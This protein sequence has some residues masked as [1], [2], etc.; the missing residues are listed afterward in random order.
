MSP[1]K[2]HRLKWSRTHLGLSIGALATFCLAHLH[3]QASYLL[4]SATLPI[5]IEASVGENQQPQVVSIDG[6]PTTLHPAM[7]EHLTQFIRSKG[8]P[9]A[10]VVVTEVAT[11]KIL[12]MAQGRSPETWGGSVHTA[13]HGGFPAASLFKTVV[14]AAAFEVAGIESKE[15]IGLW[16]SCGNVHQSASWLREVHSAS[17]RSRMTL[18]RAYGQSCNSFFAKLAVSDL[19]LNAL[20]LFAGRFGWES[21]VRADFQ[22]PPSPFKP[23]N[24]ASASVYSVGRFAAGFGHV[25]ISAVHAAWMTNALAGDGST[26]PLQLFEET[27]FNPQDRHRMVSA[28]TARSLR[29]VMK[30]TIQGGTASFAFQR[31]KHRHLRYD[32]GGKTGTLTGHAPFGVTTW[33]AGA[34]PI[35][36]PEVVVA[37]IVVLEDLW[38]IKGP[39]LAA[40]ALWA[41]REYHRPE[42]ET[43]AKGLEEVAH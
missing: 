38:H 2:P 21:P 13:L 9:I 26:P 23:P 3:G 33:F 15:G 43:I 41:Y 7:Q 5:S 1:T 42:L 34:M 4:K 22:I 12:A 17:Q 11:G 35:E 8:N 18:D 40:E 36:K 25:G 29:E 20:I 39:N 28:Q 6:R 10:A 30:S 31:G 37:A 32:V 19:G 16:G 14:A 27:A 24:V